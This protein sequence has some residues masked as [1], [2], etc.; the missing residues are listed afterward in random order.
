MLKTN[1]L[2]N[3]LDSPQ[4]LSIPKSETYLSSFIEEVV[5]IRKYKEKIGVYK[6]LINNSLINQGLKFFTSL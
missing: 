5:Q 4:K 3:Y 2:Y 1:C 6:I